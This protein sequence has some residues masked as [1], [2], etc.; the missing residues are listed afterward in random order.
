[1]YWKYKRDKMREIKLGFNIEFKLHHTLY[2]YQ[3]S[4]IKDFTHTYVNHQ[5]NV[6]KELHKF[7]IIH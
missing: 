4:L 2:R 3:S 5:N 1:M 6:I 7:Y